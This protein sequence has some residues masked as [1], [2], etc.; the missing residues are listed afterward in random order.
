MKTWHKVAYAAGSL[1]TAVSYQAF[2][3]RIQFFYID[4]I[5][6]SAATVGVV[7]FIYGLWNAI[8]D[9]LMG[10]LSDRTR[11]RW[12]RRIPYIRFG[13]IPLG[14]LFV[15]LWAPPG[16]IDPALVVVYFFVTIFL[17]DGL[18]SLIVIA[19]TALFPEMYQ[20]EYERAF[21]AGLREGFSVIG[22]IIGI[23]LPAVL[24][25]NFGWV[26]MGAIIAVVTVG[27]FLVSLLGSRED[28][29]N[30]P[31]QSLGL[32]ASLRVTL[33]NRAFLWFMVANLSKEIIFLLLV[34]V[35]PFY[36]K[37]VI[38]LTDGA[39]VLGMTMDAATQETF[40]LGAL[41]VLAIPML[42][43][44]TR[45]TQ[46]IGGR[47]A[48]QVGSLLLAP[49]LVV[50]FL[51]SD[52][53]TAMLGILLMALGFPALLM[54]HNL[55]LADLIDEDELNIGQRREGA[56]F[57]VNGAIIRLAFAVQGI[58]FT[59]ILPLS[60]YIAPPEGVG[61]I[62]QPASAILGFRILVGVVPIVC[63][64]VSLFA[65][66]RYPLHGPRLEAVQ[67]RQAARFA[68][69]FATPPAQDAAPPARPHT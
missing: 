23:A 19:W 2:A 36:A 68:A 1:G 47:R 18:W 17:F 40:A 46:R 35:F 4:V 56:Y 69:R 53:H 20:R 6:I 29:A 9:P 7:W 62:E 5:G 39:V 41:F 55:L 52:F 34:A 49:G 58:L 24:V 59:F 11:T 33:A 16:G 14:V 66:E 30:I 54:T 8:N 44:W 27:S 3:N 31:E 50:M 37:Y 10:D 48:W 22:L 25:A 45:I 38:H 60:G 65:L 43:V 32:R 21:V 26:G 42:F 12:G 61:Y 15:L 64:G 63:L 67:S 57:G 13:A 51:A 28:P